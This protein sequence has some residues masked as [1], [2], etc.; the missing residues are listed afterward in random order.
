M[1]DRDAVHDWKDAAMA[2]EDA[3]LNLVAALAMEQRV[4][5]RE[6]SAAVRAAEEIQRLRVHAEPG[7]SLR[8]ATRSRRE[9]RR[10]GN[11]RYRAS[12]APGRRRSRGSGGA[13]RTA[14]DD[15][16]AR[17]ACA[18]PTRARQPRGSAAR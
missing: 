11:I 8:A 10:G 14:C 7:R 6:P 3:V 5:E 18:A 12:G 13:V 17:P 1:Q 16:G 2:S 15:S 9:Y 4:D